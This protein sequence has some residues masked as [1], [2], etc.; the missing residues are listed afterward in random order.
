M[1]VE[2]GLEAHI[3]GRSS[4]CRM[5]RVD[6]PVIGDLLDVH[7][8]SLVRSQPTHV[9]VQ[10]MPGHISPEV[11]HVSG[12]RG[13]K[14]LVYPLADASDIMS[15]MERLPIDLDLAGEDHA[16]ATQRATL[17]S[18]R[19]AEELA[20]QDRAMAGQ[21]VL[22]LTPGPEM[23]GWGRATYLGDVM[24]KLGAI[25][26]LT[27]TGWRHL[28]AEEIVRSDVDHII[29]ASNGPVDLPW[30]LMD[31]LDSME[32]RPRVS[33]LVHEGL[34]SPS[35]QLPELAEAMRTTLSSTGEGMQP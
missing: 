7:W 20:V 1:L 15:A 34:L 32:P 2:L 26:S 31:H 9:L 19:L 17:F 24:E 5:S 29:L 11:V 3:V 30:W 18:D 27:F 23:L 21:R 35:T 12:E 22:L 28:G 25:N 4:F 6:V 13:W 10:G 8:E 16:I 14:L 33:Q